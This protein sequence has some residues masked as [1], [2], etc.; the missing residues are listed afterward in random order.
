MLE[1]QAVDMKYHKLEREV[2]ESPDAK[3][4]SQYKAQYKQSTEEVLRYNALVEELFTT[5]ERL[6]EQYKGVSKEVV[7]L[8]ESAEVENDEKQLDFYIKLLEKHAVSLESLER[9]CSR[10]KSELS[11]YQRLAKEQIDLA[12]KCL[13]KSKEYAE[14]CNVIKEQLMGQAKEYIS[15]MKSLESEIESDMLEVY[16]TARKNKKIPV[17]VVFDDVNCCCG[18]CSMELAVDFVDKLKS[19]KGYEECPNCGRVIYKQ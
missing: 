4:L 13:I 7:E 1:Y 3:K 5:Q 18:G 2:T 14:R 19:G 8:S 6:D 16:K 11:N 10:I 17:F 12:G 15:A 9:E